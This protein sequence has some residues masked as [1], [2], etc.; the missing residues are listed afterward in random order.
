M[1]YKSSPQAAKK[2]SLALGPSTVSQ[3]KNIRMLNCPLKIRTLP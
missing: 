2:T 1:A 3:N